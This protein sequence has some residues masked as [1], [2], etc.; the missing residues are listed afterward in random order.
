MVA[1]KSEQRSGS[2][3]FLNLYFAMARPTRCRKVS[4]SVITQLWL[5]VTG[6]MKNV[7]S[8]GNISKQNKNATQSCPK[9]PG[10]NIAVGVIS[11]YSLRNLNLL[12][13]FRDRVYG[14]YGW[15]V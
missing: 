12:A 10:K 3:R 4:H 13:S 8:L 7:E 14:S 1:H 2:P 9:L 15:L 6:N 11:C 5:W